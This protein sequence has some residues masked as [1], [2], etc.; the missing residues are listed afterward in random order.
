MRARMRCAIMDGERRSLCGARGEFGPDRVFHMVHKAPAQALPVGVLLKRFRRAANLTQ[1]ELAE[2]SGVSARTISDMERGLMRRARQETVILLAEALELNPSDRELFESYARARLPGDAPSRAESAADVIPAHGGIYHLPAQLTPLLGRERDEAAIAHLLQ[3]PETRLLTLTGA[4]GIG[5]TRLAIQV[6]AALTPLFLDGVCFVALETVRE[7]ALVLPAIAQGLNVR[8]V[9][10]QSLPDTLKAY[11]RRKSFLLALDNFEQVVAAGPALAD[12]LA[13]CPDLKAL[14]T[15]RTP[16]RVRGEHEFVVPSLALPP[17]DPAQTPSLDELG[18]YPA[19]ALLVQRSR[20]VQPT[21]ALTQANAG[22]VAEICRRLDGIPL[23]IELAAARGKLL[24]PNALLA[25]MNGLLP[26]LSG[27]PR[28]LPDRQRT[29][30]QAIRWSYDLLSPAEQKLFRELAVFAGGWSLDAMTAVSMPDDEPDGNVYDPLASLID[31]S[32]VQ[33]RDDQDGEPRY[34]MFETMREF[35]MRR[36][37]ERGEDTPARRRHAR[38]WL[39]L[40]ETAEAALRGRDAAAWQARLARDIG[41]VRAALTWAYESGDTELGLRLGAAL[42]R[43]WY[44]YGQPSEGLLWIERLLARDAESRDAST[45]EETRHDSRRARALAGAAFL[46]YWQGNFGRASAYANEGLAL[47]RRVD[48]QNT[49]AQCRRVLGETAMEQNDRTRARSLLEESLGDYRG[50]GDGWGIA[51]VLNDLGILAT[52]EGDY[53]RAEALL[54]EALSLFREVGEQGRIAAALS[55]LADVATYQGNLGVAIA[56]GEESALLART[57]RDN[58]SLA[59]SLLHLGLTLRESG[60][61]DR[62]VTLLRESL[63]LQQERGNVGAIAW[64]LEI[65]AGIAV[66]RGE[67]ERSA[68]LYGVA[69]M[70]RETIGAPI[71]TGR[72]ASYQRDVAATRAGLAESEFTRVWAA[73][74]SAPLPEV[75]SSALEAPAM[76]ERQ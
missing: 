6:A 72:R 40:A 22:A 16:L 38:Y 3:Q 41:N 21:F 19:V 35:G 70:A 71:P 59:R 42:T 62:A 9:G 45:R 7:P 37:I 73:G 65:L 25:R 51:V 24:P 50:L 57:L 64:C 15:S 20:A 33:Q 60:D 76:P 58:G 23:S 49:S 55:Y 47:S 75:I 30:E 1:E 4:P 34:T 66:A 39:A 43:F 12:L 63:V 28:D 69:E 10:G 14:I 48:D 68:Y 54:K 56:L 36:L 31:M 53:A 2:R 5:K 27:G 17:H 8:A 32:L 13:E 74:R 18:R 11:L 67:A 29:M 44:P 46:A 52:D 61:L 26:I